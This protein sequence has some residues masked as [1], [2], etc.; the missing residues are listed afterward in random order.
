MYVQYI[1]DVDEAQNYSVPVCQGRGLCQS[2][3]FFGPAGS[4][5]GRRSHS[6][7]SAPSGLSLQQNIKYSEPL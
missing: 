3:S 7:G 4:E 1:F 5:A 6:Q 2:R